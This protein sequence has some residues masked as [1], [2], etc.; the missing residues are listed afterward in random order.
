MKVAF[1]IDNPNMPDRDYSRILE[2]NPGIGGTEYEALLV[3]YLLEIRQNDIV[4]TLIVNNHRVFP[5]KNVAVV[6]NLEDA[7]S[8][9]IENNIETIVIDIKSYDYSTIKQKGEKLS[10]V[11]WAANQPSD[12]I[13]HE[14]SITDNIKKIVCCGREEMELYRDHMAT[15]KSTYIY[16]F[17][18]FKPI[19]YYKRIISNRENHNVVYMGSITPNKGFHELAKAWKDVCIK[20]PDAQ[21]YVIGGGNLYDSNKKLGKYGIADDSY[22]REF[23]NFV[24]DQN[25]EILPSVHFLGVLSEEKY[26]VMG[27]CKVGVPNPT[28][29]S[30][31]F[32]ICGI[33][34]QLM[35]CNITTIYH[36]AYL[37]T[38]YNKRYL[39]KSTDSLSEYLVTR[40]LEPS[41][42][43]EKIYEFLTN[44]FGIETNMA[45]WEK[46][47]GDLDTPIIEPISEYN[48]NFKK[49]KDILFNIKSRCAF[50]ENLPTVN[51]ITEHIKYLKNH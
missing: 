31:T 30:E 17:F 50:L 13:L 37:D 34:M 20:V 26:E 41:D 18:P 6:G 12:K 2:G 25:G 51:K 43:Y 36:P 16:N 45:K 28:G 21:L 23:I 11:I 40:L 9:C 27:K 48:Y 5:Q 14:I 29:V 19:E 1:F 47:L 24:T 32:C 22:E 7:F 38:I 42:D 44:K 4:P 39:Y 33:E 3:S 49:L 8:Y 35:G 46:I 15:V 10:I